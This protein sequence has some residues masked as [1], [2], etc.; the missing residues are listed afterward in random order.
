VT[1]PDYWLFDWRLDWQQRI[2][3]SQDMV[4]S[5]EVNNVFNRT[6]EIGNFDG[7]YELG[8]Q[9]WLGMTYNF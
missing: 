2:Y 7:T 1:R 4:I 6:P 5:L 8:R 3:R 9:F